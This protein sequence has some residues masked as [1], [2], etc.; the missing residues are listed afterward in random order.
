MK[1]ILA[2]AVI[3][4]GA[5]VSLSQ[6]QYYTPVAHKEALKHH[7]R[8][9]TGVLH[10]AFSKS[11]PSRLRAEYRQVRKTELRAKDDARATNRDLAKQTRKLDKKSW[12]AYRQ[13]HDRYGRIKARASGSYS[14]AR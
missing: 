8:V 2:V 12:A 11:E 7:P 5:G 1:K 10:G 9:R 6:A 14:A 13:N 3:F 4:I